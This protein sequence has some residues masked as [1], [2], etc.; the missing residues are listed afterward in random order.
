M[1]AGH[2][3]PEMYWAFGSLLQLLHAFFWGNCTV[4]QYNCVCCS[5]FQQLKVLQSSLPALAQSEA[6]ACKSLIDAFTTW[7]AA[8]HA[9]SMAGLEDTAQV[10][11]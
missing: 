10:R 9:S 3:G 5:E 11:C 4:F 1:A 7:F 2:N 8:N 6:E